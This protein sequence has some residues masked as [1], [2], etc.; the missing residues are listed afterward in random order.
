MLPWS[1]NPNSYELVCNLGGIAN[2][3]LNFY[4]GLCAFEADSETRQTTF[5]NNLIEDNAKTYL[6]IVSDKPINCFDYR[7]AIQEWN[8]AYIAARDTE[9][10]S[11]FTNDPTFTV[12]F[13][14]S[15]VT[16]FKVV[17]K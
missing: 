13:K 14:N 2:F 3:K 6:N 16:V 12:T 7:L 8:I 1:K 15:E 10:I 11:R 17:N 5:Y 9:V 4:V